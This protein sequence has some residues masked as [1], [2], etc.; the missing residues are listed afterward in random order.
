M[1][2]PFA[3]MKQLLE[4]QALLQDREPRDGT[5]FGALVRD[6]VGPLVGV[7]NKKLDLDRDAMNRRRLPAPVNAPEA[8]DAVSQLAAQVPAFARRYLAECARV[9]KDP[10][11]YADLV[12]DQLPGNVVDALPILLVDTDVAERLCVLVPEWAPYPGWIGQLVEALRSR[13][14]DSTDDE[15]RDRAAQGVAAEVEG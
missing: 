9:D 2:D 4:V 15:E 10:E 14:T 8:T 5:D 12:L 11:L 3:A 6:G 1:L 7:L 13:V